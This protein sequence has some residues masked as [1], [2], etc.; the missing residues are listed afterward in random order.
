M[1]Y[2]Y[3]YLKIK[4]TFENSFKLQKFIFEKKNPECP[5]AS[6]MAPPLHY[7]KQNNQIYYMFKSDYFR[8]HVCIFIKT[9]EKLY[10][11]FFYCGIQRE[12][13]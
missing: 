13:E 8:D 9:I 12:S 1:I 2:F 5:T 3:I 11:C 4:H 6:K 7:M 10:L